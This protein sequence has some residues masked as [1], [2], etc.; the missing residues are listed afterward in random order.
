MSNP[1]DVEPEQE[2]PAVETIAAI[3]EA[4]H[5]EKLPAF[6]NIDDLFDVLDEGDASSNVYNHIPEPG[7]FTSKRKK[8]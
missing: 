8:R 2:F 1:T 5:P 6:Q 4:Q 3:K 7:R